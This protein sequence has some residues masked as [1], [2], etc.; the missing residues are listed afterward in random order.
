MLGLPGSQTGAALL[1][2]IAKAGGTNEY[3]SPAGYA[4]LEDTFDVLAK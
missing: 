2:E 3:V 4:E 1:T